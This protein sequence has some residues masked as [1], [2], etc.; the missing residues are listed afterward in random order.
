MSLFN[1]NVR[2]VFDRYYL[3]PYCLSH[4]GWLSVISA[5]ASLGEEYFGHLEFPVSDFWFKYFSEKL[6]V[7]SPESRKKALDVCAGTG[8][9]CLNIMQRKLFQQCVAID[10]SSFAVERLQQ[11][12]IEL[13]IEGIVARKDDVMAT[14]F[15]DDEFDS[16][17]GNSFLHHLPDNYAFLSEMR[18]V[19]K[20]GGV[21]CLTGEPTVSSNFLE[22][23]ILDNVVV[24]LRLLRLKK[25]KTS[26]KSSL[27]DIWVYESQTLRKMLEDCGYVDIRIVGF[28]LLVP[29]LNG[30]TALILGRLTGRSMQP[31]WFWRY[32]GA[33]DRILFGWM[34]LNWHS[35]FVIAARKPKEA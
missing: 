17:I 6:S 1:K 7:M 29:L 25:P 23:V 28:G 13:G 15:D 32:L 34:P 31:E 14:R 20:P 3:K 26:G 30:P 5:N 22:S 10:N 16:V 11:R 12:A 4:E 35:H 24:V 19:L 2:G 27:T 9:L 18:R 8:T 33:I 21:L